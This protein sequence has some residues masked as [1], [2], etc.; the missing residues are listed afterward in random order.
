VIIV[1]RRIVALIA[2][3]V[4]AVGS[5]A[6]TSVNAVGY[7]NIS[8]EP[9]ANLIANPLRAEDMRISAL[10]SLSTLPHGTKIYKFDGEKYKVAI[11]YAA[12]GTFSPEGAG[13]ETL[14]PGEGAFIV[15]P[16]TQPF[17]VTFVG[18]IL[19]GNLTNPIPSGLSLRSSMVPWE[20]TLEQLGFVPRAIDQVYLFNSAT[21]SFE[22][23]TFIPGM[24]WQPALRK[25]RVGEAFFIRTSEPRDW[26]QVFF[27]DGGGTLSALNANPTVNFLY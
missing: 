22:T 9:G 27:V 12:L 10:F 24:G 2:L 6:Q 26:V 4:G 19:Q 20:A 18:E 13:D 16:T 5:S 25:I 17:T 3:L 21:Q 14:V 7:I 15:N 8:V 1:N 11:F 23:R